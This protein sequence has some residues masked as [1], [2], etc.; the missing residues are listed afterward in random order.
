MK[1]GAVAMNVTGGSWNF[2]K[3][4]LKILHIRLLSS[5]EIRFIKCNI[6]FIAKNKAWP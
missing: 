6:S 2:K 3:I 1:Q 5:S 4:V